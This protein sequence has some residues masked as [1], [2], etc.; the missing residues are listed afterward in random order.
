MIGAGEFA[1]AAIVGA[2]EQQEDAWVIVED[3]PPGDSGEVVLGVVADGLGGHIAGA[4]ASRLA[5]DG[6]AAG[7]RKGGGA[8]RERLRRA[9]DAANRAVRA[10]IDAEPWLLGMGTTLIAAA[11][12]ESGFSWI[13]VGDSLIYRVGDGRAERVNPLHTIGYELDRRAERGEISWDRARFH[14][15]RE[16]ITSVVMGTGIEKVAEGEAMLAPDEV[17]V[18][19]SDGILTLSDDAIG[20]IASK[21]RREGAQRVAAVLLEAV[22]A[23]GNARQ[24]N[25]T[26]IVRALS[27][28]KA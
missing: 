5:V 2:R 17:V 27:P 10:T 21:R 16:M 18:L 3:L 4:R 13:S 9:L 7:F 22:A 15:D 23:A 14:Q 1:G 25:T 12:G 24:D 26:V 8:P 28:S 20:E 6:F 11:F 19:A